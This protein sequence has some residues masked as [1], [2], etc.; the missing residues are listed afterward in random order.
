VTRKKGKK[1]DLGV[2]RKCKWLNSFPGS[3]MFFFCQN[4]P[5]N[6]HKI[7]SM[8]CSK[9]VTKNGTGSTSKLLKLV[10]LRG[11]F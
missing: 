8:E 9:I 6:L 2:L 1:E 10:V 3:E 7:L 4:L 5:Y 11:K